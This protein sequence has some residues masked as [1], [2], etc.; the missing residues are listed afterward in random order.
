MY[1]VFPAHRA[2]ECIGGVWLGRRV[3]EGLIIGLVGWVVSVKV[4]VFS[5]ASDCIEI[6]WFRASRFGVRR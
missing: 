1:C 2:P 4:T 6:D 3:S 5:H